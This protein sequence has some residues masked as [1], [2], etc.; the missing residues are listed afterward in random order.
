MQS[1]RDDAGIGLV[2]ALV[3]VALTIA[4][5]VG[6]AT[7]I[8]YGSRMQSLSGNLTTVR[9]LA[10]ERVEQLRLL[11]ATS[12]QRQNGGSL[13]ANVANYFDTT[14]AGFTRRWLVQNGPAST[15]DVT[16]VVVPANVNMRPYQVR[17]LL[18]R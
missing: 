10:T 1:L 15:K 16:V 3:A 2:E 12:A 9:A 6:A 8:L 11:P 17:V 13:T 5:V 18:T 14:A 4:C 7:M